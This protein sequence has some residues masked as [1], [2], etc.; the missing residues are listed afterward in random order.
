MGVDVRTTSSDS[1]FESMRLR[2]IIFAALLFVPLAELA[3]SP[4]S[5]YLTFNA[6]HWPL[7]LIISTSMTK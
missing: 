7:Q 5:L 1:R 6:P 2:D 3:A 4:S